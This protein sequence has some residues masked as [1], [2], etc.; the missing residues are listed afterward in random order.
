MCLYV[1]VTITFIFVLYQAKINNGV[2]QRSIP[3][4]SGAQ[5]FHK[6]SLNPEQ[7]L[8]VAEREWSIIA[9]RKTNGKLFP[10]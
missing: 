3:N 9:T 6:F 5:P 4:A 8:S 7:A 1:V 2:K 10:L